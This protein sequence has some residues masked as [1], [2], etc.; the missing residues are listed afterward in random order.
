M[1]LPAAV[2]VWRST[3]VRALN[4]AQRLRA[5]FGAMRAVSACCEH[6]QR[7]LVSNDTHCTQL[8][9]S[10]PQRW[11]LLSPSSGS[12][13]RLPRGA[14]ADLVRSHQVGRLRS[15]RI[16]QDAAWS[17]LLRWPRRTGSLRTSGAP[18]VLIAALA[19]LAI[20]HGWRRVEATRLL[21]LTVC[22]VTKL[23]RDARRALFEQAEA[24][25]RNSDRK[26]DVRLG[27]AG[28]DLNAILQR[29]LAWLNRRLR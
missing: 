18:L 14:A 15:G 17:A 1:P 13:S 3:V 24:P 20:A 27:A 12:D 19:V 4:S 23:G 7:A 9:R 22:M 25:P 16:L 11:H 21:Y 2:L 6:S 29:L 8:C 5:S 26:A 28:S 10:T